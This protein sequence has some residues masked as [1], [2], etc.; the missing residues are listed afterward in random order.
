MNG[1]CLITNDVEDLGLSGLSYKSIGDAVEYETLPRLL[2]LY[3][4]Y[5]VKATL[6]YLAEYAEKH[7]NAVRMAIERGHEIGC[8]GLSHAQENG[9]DIMPAKK[10]LEHLLHAK[11]ILEDIAGE[12]V[13]SF[14][15]P[16]LRVNF[17]TPEM[18]QQAGFI[19][20][21]S[22]ASQRMDMFMSLG[23]KNKLQWLKAPR[24]AYE[25]DVH[26]LA[27]RGHSGIYEAPVSSFCFPYIG[28]FMRVFP[29]LNACTRNLL[30]LETK[31][32]NKAINFLFHPSEAVQQTEEQKAIR[33]RKSNPIAHF[34]SDILRTHLKL[35][36]MDATAID[37]LEKEIVYWQARQYEFCTMKEYIARVTK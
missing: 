17:D 36:H 22:V 12:E 19:I 27:R 11:E 9:F 28:T 24:G 31:N 2:D 3:D 30:Y 26:N 29:F 7:P 33:Q 1:Y 5:N 21:S 10:Q 4:H 6:F 20:D 23:S 8:H 34:F 16:A 15:A 18:L 37:L 32:T 35:R 25:T 13:T 14:R